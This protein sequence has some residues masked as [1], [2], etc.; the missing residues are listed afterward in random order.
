MQ[1]KCVCRFSDAKKALQLAVQPGRVADPVAKFM[2]PC[3]RE[4]SRTAK[5][6]F[7]GKLN[8]I[9]GRRIEDS[10][11]ADANDRSAVLQDDVGGFGSRP[12]R[13]FDARRFV[14][15]DTLDL[16]RMED[17]IVLEDVR[18]RVMA[19]VLPLPRWQNRDR[20]ERRRGP[21]TLF[22]FPILRAR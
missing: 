7:R 14:G 19:S 2:Q 1:L 5:R 12:R 9:G 17:G 13:F 22:R 20:R 3:R 4:F 15:R 21:C 11:S 6:A 10:I 16:R 8:V 18:V